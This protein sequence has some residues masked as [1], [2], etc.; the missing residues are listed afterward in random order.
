[1]ALAELQSA[2]AR[3]CTDAA[4]RA[5]LREEPAA[6]AHAAALDSTELAALTRAWP[7]LAGFAQSLIHKRA[8]EAAHAI[9]RAAEFLGESFARTFA[10]FGAAH[11]AARD[12]SLDAL[13]FLSWLLRRPGHA[14]HLRETARYEI[15]WIEM[16]RERRWWRF[17]LF[18]LLRGRPLVAL[19][20][21]F[22]GRAGCS[23]RQWP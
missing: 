9:P 1:M 6:F 11:P 18:R 21:R 3:L 16:R 7:T 8:R 19:W 4:A 14:L 13:A 22:P 12:P 10:E 2:V 17:G 20:W 5:Q 23:Y 15:A